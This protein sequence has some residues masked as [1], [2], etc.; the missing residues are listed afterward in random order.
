MFFFSRDFFAIII[1]NIFKN[2]T[3]NILSIGTSINY[4]KI[5][6]YRIYI[7]PFFFFFFSVLWPVKRTL[8]DPQIEKE[9]WAGEVK[10][11]RG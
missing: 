3:F 5:Y 4:H 8:K 6:Y 11:C 1:L 10:T 7:F 2:L 9:M